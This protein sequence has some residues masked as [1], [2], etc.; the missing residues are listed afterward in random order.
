MKYFNKSF[1]KDSYSDGAHLKSG[2]GEGDLR[3]MICT[4]D[5]ADVDRRMYKM[6]M[7]FNG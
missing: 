2:R 7:V 4:K 3:C 5:M 6:D 1:T